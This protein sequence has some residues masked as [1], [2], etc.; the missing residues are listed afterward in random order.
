[1]R[2]RTSTQTLTPHSLQPRA[3]Q[4][5][6]ETEIVVCVDL[7]SYRRTFDDAVPSVTAS[8]S[9]DASIPIPDLDSAVYISVPFTFDDLV[10]TSRSSSGASGRAFSGG[11]GD[12]ARESPRSVLYKGLEKGVAHLTGAD[13]HSCLLRAMCEVI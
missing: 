8:L 6:D 12:V 7:V 4:G 10:S 9:F 1:M 3:E 2:P 13:G 5:R 11:L